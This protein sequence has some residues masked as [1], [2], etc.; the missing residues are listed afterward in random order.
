MEIIRGNPHISFK[1][2]FAKECEI[3]SI[4]SQTHFPLLRIVFGEITY[5][6]QEDIKTL[7]PYLQRFAETGILEP[8]T[9][10][11][12][13]W[14]DETIDAIAKA[15]AK[16]VLEVIETQKEQVDKL[17]ATNARMNY[18]NYRYEQ[19]LIEWRKFGTS[20]LDCKHPDELIHTTDELVRESAL[21]VEGVNEIEKANRSSLYYRRQCDKQVDEIADLEEQ[22]ESIRDLVREWCKFGQA[23]WEPKHPDLLLFESYQLLG[24]G[25]NGL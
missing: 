13:Q 15:S 2:Q 7:L 8:A 22:I 23:S 16:R 20:E 11:T 21:S 3:S 18:R 14:S 10:T 5:L 24:L 1:D 4:D 9:E 6:S 17:T 19:L 25:E 12:L